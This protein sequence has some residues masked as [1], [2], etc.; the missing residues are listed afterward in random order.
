MA[1]LAK[2]HDWLQVIGMFGLIASLIFVGMQI[3]QDRQIALSSIYQA[4]IVF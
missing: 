1:D 2:I 3:R 4:R